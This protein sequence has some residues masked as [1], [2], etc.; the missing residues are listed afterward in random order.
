MSSPH[1]PDAEHRVFDVAPER[2]RKFRRCAQA[3]PTQ[4][5]H[6][7]AAWR[8]P[9]HLN[10]APRCARAMVPSCCLMRSMIP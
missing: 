2:R 6:E 5:Q 1:A 9:N 10:F 8:F 4:D 7:Q 3:R